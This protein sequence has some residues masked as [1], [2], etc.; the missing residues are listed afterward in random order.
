ML[1]VIGIALYA[2]PGL[3]SYDSAF[4]LDEAR[5]WDLGD[6]HPPLMSAIWRLCEVFVSGPLGMLVLQVGALIAGLG[7]LLA[8]ELSARRA[9][10]ATLAISWYPPVLVVMAVIVKDA[11]MAGYLVLGIALLMAP[12]RWPRW[13]GL[14]ALVVASAM[15]HNAP[16]ATLAPI[17]LLW[18]RDAAPAW[19]R[20]LVG[21]LAWL[22]VTAA[23]FGITAVLTND[24]GTGFGDII[25]VTDIIGTVRYA[26]PLSDAELHELLAGTRLRVDRDIQAEFAAHYEPR[27][28][29]EFTQHP[30]PLEVSTTDAEREAVARA[31]RAIVLREPL[32]YLHHRWEIFQHVLDLHAASTPPP[33]QTPLSPEVLTGAELGQLRPTSPSFIQ[34]A[35]ARAVRGI[36]AVWYVPFVYF[37]VGLCLLPLARTRLELALLGSG[38]LYELGM[39]PVALSADYRYSHWLIL[40][41]IVAAVLIFARRYRAAAPARG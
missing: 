28:Y 39:F 23:S 29:L 17:V 27:I 40:S 9:A 10:A 5:R 33:F 3:M 31:W 1:A 11:Q 34:R 13:A 24:P 7:I 12:R 26:E 4:Q 35:A 19:R 14:G 25:R 21:A 15:R 22:A 37:A 8:R 2:L 20:W 41:V 38:L 36:G 32:A 30:Q 16:A 18:A 6:Q